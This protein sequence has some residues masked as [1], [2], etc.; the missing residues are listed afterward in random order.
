MALVLA[1]MLIAI[2]AAGVTFYFS[3]AQVRS[4]E[5]DGWMDGWISRDISHAR[6]LR[7]RAYVCVCVQNAANNDDSNTIVILISVDALQWSYMTS[8]NM[9]EQ[10]RNLDRL[11]S[12]GVRSAMQSIY[13]SSTFPNHY[14]IGSSTVIHALAHTRLCVR[15][16]E[17]ERYIEMMVLQ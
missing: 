7:T 16:N 6:S 9:T 5:Q 17:F 8:G 4:R 11:T 2:A 14:T 1:V 10:R 12:S 3:L 15:T 13:P